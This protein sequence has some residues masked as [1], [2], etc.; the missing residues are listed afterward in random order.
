MPRFTISNHNW[1]DDL[2]FIL[3]E[4]LTGKK[5]IPYKFSLFRGSN[6]LVIGSVVQWYCNE[7]S[8]IWGAG[9]LHQVDKLKHPKKVLAVRGPETR[10]ELIKLGIDCPE[11][12]GDP[13]LLMPLIYFPKIKKRYKVG[14]ILH[15]SDF[16][17]DRK[18]QI[19]VGMNMEDILYIDIVNYKN[20]M[21]FIDQILSCDVILSS[22]L[23]GLIVS[24]AYKI[25]NIWTNFGAIQ[26]N[27]SKFK[28]KDYYQS[29]GKAIETPN[30][31]NELMSVPNLDG[32]IKSKWTFPEIDL[33]PLIASCPFPNAKK[34]L[35]YGCH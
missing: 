24:D 19:P 34:M 6:Y 18:L 21:N 23:H 13:A 3:V 10:K 28:Y 20:W 31:Y 29:I 35:N 11:V 32:Y 30:Q 25:P 12:Y 1:G 2:N 8:I 22:S 16:K 14:V 5:V 15:Y 26:N 17:L 33:S 7:R 27:S 4:E 9:L